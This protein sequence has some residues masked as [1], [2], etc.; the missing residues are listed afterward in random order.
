MSNTSL[1]NIRNK[2]KQ[3]RNWD[4]LRQLPSSIRDYFARDKGNFD[5]SYDNRNND[6][7][8]QRF[9]GVKYPVKD[10]EF[11]SPNEDICNIFQNLFNERRINNLIEQY[12]FD[13]KWVY[14][15][16]RPF[17]KWQNI[18]QTYY[19]NEAYFWVILVFN[20]ITDPFHALTD[21]NIVR[22]PNL[23]FI[24]DLPYTLYFDFSAAEF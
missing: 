1:S 7:F 12:T 16:V 22:I 15:P 9:K 14:H 5:K 19:N 13:R 11:G 24:F 4:E 10:R 20:R 3:Q 2:T 6:T 18:S 17:E 23:Q 21:F 8:L